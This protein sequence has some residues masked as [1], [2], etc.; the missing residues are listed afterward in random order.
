MTEE[1]TIE[2]AQ[3]VEPEVSMS[4]PDL[5]GMEK[6]TEGDGVVPSRPYSVR[7]SSMEDTSFAVAATAVPGVCVKDS[8]E[9][10]IMYPQE[11]G[12][13]EVHEGDG[14]S[15][16][17]PWAQRRSVIRGTSFAIIASGTTGGV[18]VRDPDPSEKIIVSGVPLSDD[19]EVKDGAA[20][21]SPRRTEYGK[22]IRKDYE[23]GGIEEKRHNM[24]E[25]APRDDGLSNTLTTVPRDNIVIED[26]TEE[27]PEIPEGDACSMLTPGRENKRQNGPRF[28][29]DGTAFTLTAADKNGVA[30][31]S[32]GRLRIRYLTPLECWRLQ[33]FPDEAYYKAVEAGMSKTAAYKQAGNSIT[34]NVLENIFTRA[35]K[36]QTWK[37]KPT[38][39]DWGK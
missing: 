34:V 27:L 14:V 3:N 8:K 22:E 19:I 32:N 26:P 35:F 29:T 6:V 23:S 21:L 39:F 33:A 2:D 12:L 24:V 4:W 37:K 1:T 30:Q 11:G 10:V 9:D 25:F 5:D 13:V 16:S 38:L 7:K 28:K 18:C 17:R 20:V 15:P 31:N 36:E